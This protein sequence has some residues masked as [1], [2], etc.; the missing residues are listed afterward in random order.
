MNGTIQ[1]RQR[2]VQKAADYKYTAR[3]Q[4]MLFAAIAVGALAAIL[5]ISFSIQSYGTRQNISLSY[6]I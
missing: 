6:K 4:S 3:E 2:F 5:P 1:Y